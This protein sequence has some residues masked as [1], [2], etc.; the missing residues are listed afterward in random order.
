MF[1]PRKFLIF[2]PRFLG[3]VILSSGLP[4][5][6]A[7]SGKDVEVWYLTQT[8]F[9][10]VL[11][12]HPFVAGVL[13]LDSAHKRNPFVLWNLGREMRRHR[14]DAVLDLFGN[15]L[16]AR[17]TFFSGAKIR[18][19]F[20]GQ[21]RSWAYNRIALPSSEPALSGRRKVTE[22]YLD[23]IRALGMPFT[24]PYQTELFVSEEE[25]EQ[26]RKVWERAQIRKDERVAVYAPGASWPAKHWPLKKFIELAGNLE[27]EGLRPVFVFGPKEDQLVQEFE[28]KAGKNW[29]LI[30]RPS[31]RGLVSFISGADLLVANDS[32]PMHVGPAVRTPTLGIFGPGEP[33]IWFPYDSPH[34]IAYHEVSCSHCGLDLCP[35]MVCMRDLGVEEVARTALGMVKEPIPG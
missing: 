31:L 29:L 24:G 30:H 2:R 23:Q 22:A 13:T 20:E 33:E 4:K 34:R 10:E 11:K 19:G 26:V 28:G 27:K 5:I 14:F 25:K 9:D 17:L 8:P 15:P 12:H 21:G 32:G 1:S 35:L 7:S 3:D 18:L 6:I 16:T